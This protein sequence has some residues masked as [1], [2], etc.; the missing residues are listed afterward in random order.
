MTVDNVPPQL[1]NVAATSPINENAST[2]LSGEVDDPGT[3]DTFTLDLD[4]GDPLSSMD[5]LDDSLLAPAV[6][7][8]RQEFFGREARC[9]VTS[10]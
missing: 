2:T 10:Q 8:A 7:S 3:L 5:H 1:A 6:P 9:N 4:W